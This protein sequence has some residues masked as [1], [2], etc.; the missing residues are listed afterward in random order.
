MGKCATA[1]P[2]GGVALY[3]CNGSAAQSWSA[4]WPLI[5]S[6]SGCL[7]LAAHGPP[8]FPNNKLVLTS[9]RSLLTSSLII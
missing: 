8:T 9:L 6:A 4:E 7:G 5:K 1:E 2:D 3:S